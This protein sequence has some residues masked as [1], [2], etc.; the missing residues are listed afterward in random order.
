MRVPSLP[1]APSFE[2]SAE[3][4]R[5]K[6]SCNVAFAFAAIPPAL[7]AAVALTKEAATRRGES[8]HPAGRLIPI[9]HNARRLHVLYHAPPELRHA[10][11]VVME[12]GANCW[13]PVWDDVFL[14]VAQIARVFRYDRAGFGFSDPDTNPNDRS[15]S[16]IATDL[17]M[18]LRTAGA[19]PPY[20]FVTHSLGALYSNVL[21]KLLPP[22]QVCGLVYVDASSPKT[23]SMLE[24]L[25]PRKTPPQWLATILGRLGLLRFLAPLALRPYVNAFNGDLRKQAVSTWARGDW[26]MAYTA[27]WATAIRESKRVGHGP[28]NF[29]PG[30]LGD[31][32]IC[33]LVPDVY[34]RTTGKAYIA[35]LQS[36]IAAYSS[37]SSLVEIKNC[38]HF[39][40]IERPDV[41]AHAVREVIQRATDKQL[42]PNLGLDGKDA[43]SS[44]HS[45]L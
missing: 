23:V 3:I 35:L 6:T 33:V 29:P 13:S 45:M 41:V 20:L 14:R 1:P 43:F 18:A 44:L 11:C 2:G 40:Q 34:E 15:V 30:W 12:A 38:G 8:R 22:S 42:L 39:V 32:P 5:V 19:N 36:A 24:K 7:V 27:E 26:L 37:D 21:V 31:I 16:A 25:V 28:L 4:M 10:P 9:R 17:H